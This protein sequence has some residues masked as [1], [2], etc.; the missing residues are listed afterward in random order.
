M[1]LFLPSID[2][3]VVI[4]VANYCWLLKTGDGVGGDFR[5]ANKSVMTKD[6]LSVAVIVGS[7]HVVGKESTVFKIRSAFDSLMK[8]T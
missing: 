7:A 2:W 4:E 5:T 6:N 8:Y 1:V 3:S